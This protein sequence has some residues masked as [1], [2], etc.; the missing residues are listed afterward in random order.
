MLKYQYL[1]LNIYH[2]NKI[3]KEKKNQDI[4]IIIFILTILIIIRHSSIQIF[5]SL[6]VLVAPYLRMIIISNFFFFQIFGKIF[7]K[8]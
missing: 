6:L 4:D 7:V 5:A 8:K 2:R 1:V 3:K